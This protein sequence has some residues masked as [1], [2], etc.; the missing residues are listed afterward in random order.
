MGVAGGLFKTRVEAAV[1]EVPPF[2][3]II[4]PLFKT[5]CENEL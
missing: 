1:F 2:I 3:L 5:S 4:T